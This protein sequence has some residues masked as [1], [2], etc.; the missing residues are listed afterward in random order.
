M[1]S[2]VTTAAMDADQLLAA[3]AL[4]G[5]I[6]IT[7]PNRLFRRYDE[8]LLTSGTL[9][10]ASYA[11]LVGASLTTLGTT[12]IALIGYLIGMIIGV[13]F[14]ALATGTLSFRAGVDVVDASK[15]MLGTRGAVLMLVAAFVSA[16]GWANVLIAMTSRGMVALLPSGAPVAAHGE[17]L[18]VVCALVLTVLIWLLLR[19][20]AKAMERVASYGALIQMALAVVVIG[21]VLWRWGWDGSLLRNV[22]AQSAVTG[23]RLLQLSLGVEF[24]F[25]NAL[26][27]VPFMGGLS[28][29]VQRRGHTVGPV[30]IGYP[31]V[32]CTLV[33][34]AG[35]FAA[36][37]T[38][39]QELSGMLIGV[40][41]SGF[42][43]L[44]LV[45]VMLTNLSTMVAQ[46]YIA[47]IS[48][49][50]IRLFSA[51]RWTHVVMCAL[52]PS[53][54]V[55]FFT[56]VLLDHILALLA[57]GGVMFVGMSAVAFADYFILRRQRVRMAH[58]F[59]V[60]GQGDYWFRHGVNWSAVWTI[61]LCCVVYLYWFDPASLQSKGPFFERVGASIPTLLIGIAV[62]CTLVKLWVIPRGLGGY[63]SS[64]DKG[65]E[66]AL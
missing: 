2:T 6:P 17:F 61:V 47:G 32:G 55:A 1:T 15:P 12:W 50:Q 57:Y 66:V 28:R 48:L 23:D 5:R 33:A 25:S 9:G 3:D 30:V 11:Y 43:T 49:Q 53:V 4:A 65:V 7:F 42:G 64:R 59:A 36:M 52:L 35:A 21:I 44:L 45:I 38:G 22:P 58:L 24:G 27:L 46:F 63:R 41:G 62:Y 14:V 39:Q 13:S 26:G 8:F 37:A 40:A 56:K 18:V 34:S 31:V 51:M 19:R 20:G 29:L 16:A 10:A 54:A 60:P